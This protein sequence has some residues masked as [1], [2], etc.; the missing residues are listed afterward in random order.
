MGLLERG[1]A[2]LTLEAYQGDNRE[3]KIGSLVAMYNPESVNLDYVATYETA[4]G[5]NQHHEVSWYRQVQPPML[6]LDLIL[7]ARGPQGGQPVDQ[8]LSNLRALCF[9]VG[10][11]GEAPYL[12]VTWGSMSWHGHGY[13]AGRLQTLSIAYTLFDRDA[14]PLRATATLTLRAQ[15]SDE[16]EKFKVLRGPSKQ[17]LRMPDKTSL[18]QLL[19][20]ATTLAGS[21]AYLTTAYANDADNLSGWVA[22]QTLITR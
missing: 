20:Q 14:K 1:L 2:K 13:F 17:A 6:S 21:A 9:T 19:A 11:K 18:P 15:T 3:K 8:Q 7:D 10:D 4:S 16:M 12:R 5:V 22:G